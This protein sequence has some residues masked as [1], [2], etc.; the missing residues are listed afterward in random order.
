MLVVGAGPA[1]LAAAYELQRAGHD[2]RVFEARQ[3]AGGRF[4]T[5][6]EP[7]SDGLYAE[8]G[9]AG[10]VSHNPGLEYAREMGLELVSPPFS[11]LASLLSIRGQRIVL[12]GGEPVEWP[13]PLNDDEQGLSLFQLATKYFR[14]PVDG[15]SVT[16]QLGTGASLG[17]EALALDERSLGDLLDD[18]GASE[19]ARQLL[20]IGYYNGYLEPEPASLLHLALERGAF[21]GVTGFYQVAGGNDRLCSEL[22][23]RLGGAVELGRPVRSVRQDDAGVR[24][25]V[26]GPGGTETVEGDFVVLTPPPPVLRELDFEPALDPRVM[27]SFDE[28]HAVHATRVFAEARSRFWEAE[29]LSGG[30]TTDGPLE[31]LMH[32]TASRPGERG[33]LESYTYGERAQ[34][35][36]ALP[37][38]E[39][40]ALLRAGIEDLF[41]SPDLSDRGTSYAWG[42]DPWARCNFVTFRP[43]QVSEFLPAMRE[44]QGRVY[45]AGDTVGGTPGYSHGAFWSGRD[46]AARIIEA[47]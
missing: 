7:F 23:A 36:A 8:A 46:V 19:S 21:R 41:E 47:V 3:R 31:L 39:R 28:L 40:L 42:E 16:D 32:A 43:G 25:G 37:G 35:M 34:A 30:A 11:P 26:D 33:I 4:F 14:A 17:P 1:G 24:L 29:G 20:R 2:V 6:R 9:A 12:R 38:S 15:M 44:A 13:L 22:A 27:R 5:L 45:L 18:G 10:L